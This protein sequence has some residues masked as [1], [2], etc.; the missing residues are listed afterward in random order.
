MLRELIIFP[1]LGVMLLTFSLQLVDS[2]ENI[3]L[4]T[5]NFAF[6]MQNAVDCATRGV[7]I[8]ECSPNLDSYNF[9]TDVNNTIKQNQEF[10]NKLEEFIQNNDLD[11][12]ITKKEKELIIQLI[13]K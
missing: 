11:S 10:T 6:D 2:A 7:D 8:Y 12:K 3:S 13:N 5:A 1:V 4:K 9:K